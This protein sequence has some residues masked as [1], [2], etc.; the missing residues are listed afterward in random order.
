M[1][2]RAEHWRIRGLACVLAI[3]PNLTC[4]STSRFS[5]GDQEDASQECAQMRQRLTTDQTLTPAQAAEITKNME[6]A[7]CARRLPGP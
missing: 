4:C 3:A 1:K 5:P 2:V 7:G 6:K